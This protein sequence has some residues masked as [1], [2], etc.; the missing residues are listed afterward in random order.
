MAR[1][2]TSRHDK[3]GGLQPNHDIVKLLSPREAPLFSNPQ[4]MAEHLHSFMRKEAALCLAEG[5]AASAEDIEL[6]MIL[7]AGHPP[8][9]N[10]F[11]ADFNLSTADL[12]E[13]HH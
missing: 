7:G 6:A 4:E 5:V 9:R 2:S 13:T 1:A 3:K 11:P 8:F 12:H 10:L